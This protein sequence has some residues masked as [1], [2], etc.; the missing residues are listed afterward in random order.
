MPTEPLSSPQDRSTA[1]PWHAVTASFLGWTID[2]FDYSTVA[3]LVGTLASDLH[4]TKADIIWTLTATLAMRPV[5][6]LLF[7]VVADR[8]GRRF[9]LMANVIYF[10]V[11]ELL[12]GFSTNFTM[13]LILRAL[14]GIGMGGEW[15]VGASLAMETVPRRWRGFFS[16]VLQAGYPVG[17]LLAAVSLRFILPAWGWRA[18]FWA[19][20]A[21]ALL[22]IYVRMRVPE[23]EAW[24][25]H[26]VAK[27]GAILRTIS[28]DWKHF[29]F[30]VWM[31]T[32]LMFL[33]H[34]TQ[35]LYP[36][37]LTSAHGF[38]AAAVSTTAMIYNVGAIVGSVLFGIFSERFGRRRGM[39]VAMA[40]SL[41]SIPLWTFGGTAGKLTLGA[42]LMQVGVQGT[43]G[44]IPAHLN[45]LA[46]SEARSLVP[47]LAYHLGILVASPT[48]TLEYLLRDRFGYASA[49]AG[50][51]FCVI[52]LSMIAVNLSR[53][54]RGRDFLAKDA[55]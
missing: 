15:G 19:G 47:G 22:A 27:T 30:L 31:M 12:C 6:A 49:L 14:F 29:L 48:N 13:F 54:R 23:P 8:Y 28:K 45:E 26:R 10:S 9:T 40:V 3:F 55:G 4:V 53:E 36:D 18:M 2:A 50:F 52:V 39:T 32:L 41:A 5:G 37:F 24:V 34:G 25:R 33:S 38:S 1:G 43:W 16:G 42:F 11:V 46:P 7:G 44:I 17:Y 51:E 21:P 20:G 35:D